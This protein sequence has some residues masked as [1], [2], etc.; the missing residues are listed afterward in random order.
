[1]AAVPDTLRARNMQ[2]RRARIL[3]EARTLLAG[4]GF[5][6][7]NLRDLARRADVTVPT[8][9][10]LIGK[11]AD[12]FLALAAD[13]LAEIES[14]IEPAY[15][16]DALSCATSVVIESTQ[17]FGEDEAF[18]RSAFLAVEWLDQGGQHHHGVEGIYAWAEALIQTGIDACR[19]DGLLR[20]RLS[21]ASMSK[22]IIRNYRMSCRGWAF[23]HHG[24]EE[25]RRRAILDLY[26]VL[27][28]DAVETFH[29]RLLRKIAEQ[30]S[31][32]ETT[33][34]QPIQAPAKT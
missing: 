33:T 20:G 14:R 13:V 5:E 1:M 16:T 28:A 30:E 3:T 4:G 2:K 18:Y 27:A 34:T 25:F 26:I 21:D 32:H 23:G 9:Y 8:I 31:N 29:A 22:L 11:K 24:I 7:L 12:V 17:L 10:N 6:A 19:K 15:G